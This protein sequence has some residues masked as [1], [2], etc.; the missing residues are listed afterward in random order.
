MI[1]EYMIFQ[2]RNQCPWYFTIF[3]CHYVLDCMGEIST[4]GYV[5]LFLSVIIFSLTT[6]AR[7]CGYDYLNF[8]P[9]SHLHVNLPSK[10]HTPVGGGGGALTPHHGRYVPLQSHKW[11]TPELARAWKWGSLEQIVG[12]SGTDFAGIREVSGTRYCEKCPCVAHG[13]TYM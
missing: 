5:C 6:R 10:S 3:M 8:M 11:G 7:A 2:W 12:H 9:R 1:K 4:C 13:W